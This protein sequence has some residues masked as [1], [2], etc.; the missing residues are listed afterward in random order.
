[1]ATGHSCTLLWV[2]MTTWKLS[3]FMTHT[4][5]HQSVNIVCKQT[6][7]D[8]LSALAPW[9]KKRENWISHMG[10]VEVLHHLSH[11]SQ[12]LKSAQPPGA[13]KVYLWHSG[14]S[15]GSHQPPEHHNNLH[16]L[17]AAITVWQ[18]HSETSSCSNQPSE[19]FNSLHGL[20]T[21]F[22]DFQQLS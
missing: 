11:P 17:P 16:W 5:T 20:Q 1:M 6:N 13:I 2:N 19:T 12:Y 15:T 14:T 4:L 3:T 10:R 9:S 22:I 21:T 7:Y 18:W 8:L